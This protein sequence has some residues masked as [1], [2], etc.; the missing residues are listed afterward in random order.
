MVLTGETKVIA[1]VD[2]MDAA[3]AD[4]AGAVE[5]NLKHKVTHKKHKKHKVD[6]MTN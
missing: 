3:A 6:L 2:A 1:A 5:T 4:V